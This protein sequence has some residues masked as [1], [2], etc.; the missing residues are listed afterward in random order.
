ML[1]KRSFRA[2]YSFHYI[3]LGRKFL[4][5]QSLFSVRKNIIIRRC[6]IKLLGKCC[7]Y[8]NSKTSLVILRFVC[9]FIFS[10]F[11]R[12]FST[13][14]EQCFLVMDFLLFLVQVIKDHHHQPKTPKQIFFQQIF[15]NEISLALETQSASVPMIDILFLDQKKCTRFHLHS[16]HGT[17]FLDCFQILQR[18]N[19]IFISVLA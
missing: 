12:T 5:F 18:L 9:A 6:Q 4:I 14:A 2:S 11:S 3:F 10:I 8:L 13:N 7:N 15:E 19:T 16:Q 1:P 17:E